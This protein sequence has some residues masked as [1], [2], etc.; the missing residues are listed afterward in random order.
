MI[1]VFFGFDSLP[2]VSNN[3]ITHSKMEGSKSKTALQPLSRS[4]NVTIAKNKKAKSVQRMMDAF[5]T[6]N[7]GNP[8]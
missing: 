3:I 8:S 2:Y 5:C 6:V 7:T 4:K 1:F